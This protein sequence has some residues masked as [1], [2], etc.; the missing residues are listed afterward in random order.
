METTTGFARVGGARIAYQVTG[1]GPVDLVST[2]GSFVSFDVTA[3]DPKGDLYY[4]RMA[5]FSRLIR[6]DRR[7][8]GSSDPVSLDSLP[9]LEAFADETLGV[10][11]AVGSEQ[12]VLMAGYDAGPMAIVLAATRPDRISALILAGTTARFLRAED[13]P[14][15]LDPDA[16]DQLVDVFAETWGEEAQAGLYVPSRAADREFLSWFAKLQ[17]LTISPAQASAY[18]RALIDTDVRSLLPSIAIPVLILHRREFAFIPFS[19][20]E[21]LADHIAGSTL[22][23]LPGRDGPLIWEHPDLAL[24]AVEEFV[25]GFRPRAE[26]ERIIATVLFSDIVDST[27]HAEELGDRRWAALLD[28]HDTR[29]AREIASHDGTLVKT[30][31]DGFLAAFERPGNAIQT[32]AALRAQF[33]GAGIE[34]RMGIHTGEVVARA[35]GV[36]GLA[37]HLASRVMDLA[38]PG[39]ILT[40]RTVKDLV[41]GSDF[42]FVDRGTRRLKG[43]DGEWQLYSVEA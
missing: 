15:G 8:A 35:D 29:A 5:T 26:P 1:S 4:R 23:P 14:I 7:G 40:S 37:V 30:T 32:A 20:A 17:R 42:A 9:H 19:H 10:M 31:G 33:A 43:F 3:E 2:P 38:G 39:E 41:V 27:R 34:A 36:G 22:V 21:Y 13:Y 24:D 16:A 28:L 6:F 12:A 18:L 11:D 25:T